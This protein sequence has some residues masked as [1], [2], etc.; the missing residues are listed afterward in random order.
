[1]T[2]SVLVEIRKLN[3]KFIALTGREAFG[4]LSQPTKT[5]QRWTFNDG[6]VWTQPKDAYNYMVSLVAQAAT[7]PQNLPYP[8][9]QP[10]TPEQDLRVTD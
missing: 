7:D 2:E 8:F 6:T 9:D 1:M 3:E 10:L 4:H 5:S